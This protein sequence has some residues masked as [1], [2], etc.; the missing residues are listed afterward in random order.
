[1]RNSFRRTAASVL[2][3]AA[4]ACAAPAV[5]AEIR[6]NPPQAVA[7]DC[8]LQI[9]G[10][11]RP[12]D[13]AKVERALQPLRE[14]ENRT[15]CLDSAGG[16]YNE[17]IALAELFR[18]FA[19]TTRLLPRARCFSSCAIAFMGG[20]WDTQSGEGYLT[21]RVMSPRARL[22][23][24]APYLR[25]GGA[26]FDEESVRGAYGQATR[27][28]GRLLATS[29]RIDLDL[30]LVQEMLYRGQ[31]ELYMIDTFAK[32]GVFAIGLHGYY[33]FPQ[34]AG[35]EFHACQNFHAWSTGQTLA[36]AFAQSMPESSYEQIREAIVAAYNAFTANPDEFRREGVSLSFQPGDYSVDCK[37][38][39]QPPERSIEGV[40]TQALLYTEVPAPNWE[41]VPDLPQDAPM[42]A[43]AMLD[44]EIAIAELP[45]GAIVDLPGSFIWYRPAPR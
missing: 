39:Y 30:K 16:A 6:V 12:G 42:P 26:N 11:I 17:G 29:L 28:I 37:V 3:A 33:Q 27:S 18:R 15:V 36:E 2:A 35:F 19:F 31:D 23:F 4:T 21:H 38:V 7:F 13:A 1:M 45:E 25:I 14:R 24:H 32:L 8:D 20:A 5:A 44:A 9:T 10:E 41:V 22:G 40:Q 43:W 34:F